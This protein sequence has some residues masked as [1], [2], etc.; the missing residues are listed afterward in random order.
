VHDITHRLLAGIDPDA[1]HIILAGSHRRTTRAKQVLFRTGEPAERLFVLGKGRVQF[2]R[3]SSTGRE[4]AIGILGPGDVFGLGSLLTRYSYIG[5]AKVIGPGEVLVWTRDSLRRLAGKY[6]QLTSNALQIAADYVATL[7][8]RH[9]KLISETAEQRVAGAL[10]QVGVQ[11]GHPSPEGI[12][13]DIK[14][15]QL[16]SLADVSTFT[17]SRLLQRWERDDAI[18]KRRGT[19]HI[20]S[21]E[22]LLVD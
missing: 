10:A 5:T 16:A 14:N 2:G 15:E 9:E 1:R 11:I 7:A 3:I 4:I 17:V 18:K 8:D 6:P 20:I 22:K 13:V 21:P 19:V 12:E